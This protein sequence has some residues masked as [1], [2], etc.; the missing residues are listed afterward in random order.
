MG[1]EPATGAEI[2]AREPKISVLMPTFNYG[3]F[4]PEALE[5][6]LA[7]DCD[8]WELL[9]SDDASADDTAEVLRRYAAADP[10]IRLVIQSANLG[11]AANWNWCLAH[12]RGRYV[13]FLFGDDVL[14]APGALSRL[15]G[16]LDAHPDARLAASA[17][18]LLD[19]DSRITGEWA[20]LAPGL[21]S[22]PHTVVRCL[23]TRRNLIGEP[24]AVMFRRADAARGFDAA[25]R[26]LIDLEFWCHLLLDGNLAYTDAPLAGFRRHGRQ[27]TAVNHRLHRPELEA[28]ALLHRYAGAPG[29]AAA[30]PPGGLAHRRVQYEQFHYA[31]KLAARDPVAAVEAARLRR[32]LP[33]FWRLV[34]GAAHR[35]GRPFE[36]L[37]RRVVRLAAAGLA[38]FRPA[39]RRGD[40]VAALAEQALLRAAAGAPP[41]PA[42]GRRPAGDPA[43]GKIIISGTGR[44]GTTFLVRLLTELG[45]DT[46]YSRESWVVDYD[47]RCAAGLEHDITDPDAPW[48]VKNPALCDTLPPLLDRGAVAV[49]HAIIPVRALEDAARSRIRLGGRGAVPG[50]LV[51][52]ASAVEQPAILAE[53]FHRI[54]RAL[55]EH[56]IPCTFLDFP[57]L[58]RDPAYVRRRLGWLVGHIPAETFAVAFARVA[59][60]ELIHDFAVAGSG[61]HAGTGR[62]R[63]VVWGAAAALVAG[64]AVAFTL[65]R[66]PAASPDDRYQLAGMLNAKATADHKRP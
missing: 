31:R 6:V 25:F 5:S 41:G 59:R 9:V 53:R 32:E 10:R 66:G 34:L 12:A 36:H 20:P 11:L 4:L 15:A 26:Q 35:A 48:I 55:T 1:P 24:S 56:E 60:P 52:T 14:A 22:G 21:H 42:T 2:V 13:K 65:G 49:A 28:V 7:Q 62:R 16:L 33:A 46:G 23:R 29:L 58:A 50:G 61:Q 44:A 47:P 30:L 43:A 39:R 63:A 40:F 3:R 17:R 18:L 54:V 51:G 27:Q 57:R 64:G 45:L 8:D 19:R 38:P 37:A